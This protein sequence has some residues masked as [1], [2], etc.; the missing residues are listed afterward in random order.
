MSIDKGDVEESA[1][2]QW[3]GEGEVVEHLAT[4]EEGAQQQADRGRHREEGDQVNKFS[5][6]GEL[7]CK[8]IIYVEV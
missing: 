3:E 2:E 6:K 8:I 5:S 4:D 1:G 7:F